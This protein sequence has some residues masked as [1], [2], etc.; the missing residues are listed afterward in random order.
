MMRTLSLLV[1]IAVGGG[2][3]AVSREGSMTLMHE[4]IGLPV[5]IALGIVNV[6]GSLVIGIIFGRLEGTLRRDGG[7]RL[8]K[9]P[10]SQTLKDRPWWPD[11][12]ETIAAVDLFQ[13]NQA[14]QIA[15][16]LFITGF[17][18][19]YTTFSAFSLL[20]V[21]LLQAGQIIEALISVVGSV[22]LGLA[23][24]WAGVHIGC[25]LVSR[26]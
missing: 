26:A 20:T 15:A 3:G 14:L 25:R 6:L 12:D 11:G 22:T 23:A 17:L 1:C 10:H 24:A 21:Q 19:A 8:R 5:F 13:F 7:S 18:G 4:C 16:A 2:F 9:L